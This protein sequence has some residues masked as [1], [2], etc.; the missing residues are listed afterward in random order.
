MHT[1]YL[2]LLQSTSIANHKLAAIMLENE[3]DTADFI[4]G[5]YLCYAV[6][7]TERLLT[8]KLRKRIAD[9]KIK[10][11]DKYSLSEVLAKI[12]KQAARK[13]ILL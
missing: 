5:L 6:L 9:L 13:L 7:K 8:N 1:K 3:Q 11:F 10:Q 12:D 4:I 2:K